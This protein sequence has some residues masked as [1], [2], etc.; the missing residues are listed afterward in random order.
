MSEPSEAISAERV[1][2]RA[3]Q[4]RAIMLGGLGV[5]VMVL[6]WIVW[7][8]QVKPPAPPAMHQIE[9]P[10]GSRIVSTAL[11]GDR[12]A[13]TVETRTGTSILVLR[14]S[15]GGLVARIDVRPE[16]P[17]QRPVAEAR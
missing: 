16:L 3:R 2:R 17:G 11:D 14:V 9:L 7:Q 6:V 15:D 12:L 8:R 10:E 4:A 5:L 13:L 1:I